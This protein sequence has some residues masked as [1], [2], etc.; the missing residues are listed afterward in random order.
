MK[1]P[2]QLFVLNPLLYGNL[3]KYIWFKKD[4]EQKEDALS[5]FCR[6]LIYE[7]YVDGFATDEKDYIGK[8][9]F[10][11]PIVNIADL[12]CDETV[13][14]CAKEYEEQLYDICQTV[15]IVNPAVNRE[16]IVIFGAGKY[17]Q[18]V[19]EQLSRK[20]MKKGIKYFIDSD[21][22]KCGAGKYKEGVEVRSIDILA[23]VS[24]DCSIVEA[25]AKYKEMD[26]LLRKKGCRQKRF[27]FE[28]LNKEYL[29]YIHNPDDNLPIIVQYIYNMTVFF[30]D[31]KIYFYGE[32]TKR[33]IKTAKCIQLLDFKFQGFVCDDVEGKDNGEYPVKLVEDLLYEE[34]YFVILENDYTKISRLYEIGLKKNIDFNII[35]HLS[36]CNYIIKSVLDINLGY[37]YKGNGKY[38]GIAVYGEEKPND[39]K[40]AVLGGSTTDD[41]YDKR[42][43]ARILYEK[44]PGRGVTVYNGGTCGYTSTQ[45]LIKLERDILP[46]KPDLI[47]VYD[48]FND[49]C[50]DPSHPFAIPYLKKV[51]EFVSKNMEGEN[52][53]HVGNDM[54]ISDVNI[55]LETGENYFENWLT[56]IS[57]MHAVSQTKD[58]PFIAFAQPTRNNMRNSLGVDDW[59]LSSSIF[60]IQSFGKPSKNFRNEIENREIEKK[61]DYIYNLT[62]VFDDRPDVYLDSCHLNE[63]GNVIIANKVLS[64][65]AE[66]GIISI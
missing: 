1:E 62:G 20:G 63:E 49:L 61:Y 66:K 10:N 3:K 54:D 30:G 48:G 17:G 58:I 37:T 5:I 2:D 4:W 40:I 44:W 16:E 11:K 14:F 43:W 9:A 64:T 31:K 32:Q 55:G 27:Y 35:P 50:E 47:I 25:A 60:W 12:D 56:K 42:N 59:I 24:E 13:V 39:F 33:N 15:E 45:E 21:I 57:C 29:K 41:V 53:G 26:C 51:F 34:N 8:K 65:I 52:N 46:L 38:P 36:F 6:F 28:E 18:T 7:I 19:C 22:T 23:E